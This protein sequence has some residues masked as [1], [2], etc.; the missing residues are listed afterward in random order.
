MEI[1]IIG[2]TETQCTTDIPTMWEKD[3]HVI[4]HLPRQDGIHRQGVDLIQN[5]QLIEHMI[6]YECI[7]IRL[8]KVTIEPRSD[9]ITYKVYFVVYGVI[10][11]VRPI[12]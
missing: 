5:K 4:I 8:L 7:S 9:I 12:L 2:I 3:E 1:Y 10:F 11:I 6:N